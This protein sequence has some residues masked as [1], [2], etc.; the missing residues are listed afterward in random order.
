[1]AV[2][3]AR[4]S[5]GQTGPANV[6]V[7]AYTCPAGKTAIVKDIA[8]STAGGSAVQT[9]IALTSG[10]RF[11]NIANL[12][13]AAN[14]FPFAISRFIVLEPGDQLVINA[15]QTNG[16]VWWLSGSELDGVAP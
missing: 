1:M 14:G 16:I 5:E 4:L 11:C 12:S 7:V 9:I 8:V 10:P 2:R 6:T 15:S 13:L 3:T